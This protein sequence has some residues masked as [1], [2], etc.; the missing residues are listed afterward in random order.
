[1]GR[2]RDK[3]LFNLKV[4]ESSPIFNSFEKR[5][6][7]D[8]LK[9]QL[10]Y[11]GGFA[12]QGADF[13][14]RGEPGNL[15]KVV[16]LYNDKELFQISALNFSMNPKQIIARDADVSMYHENG[17]SLFTSK[18]LFYWDEDKKEL[19]VTAEKK[20]ANLLPFKDSFFKLFINA[21]LLSWTLNS[22]FPMFTYEVGTAQE[23][24]YAFIESWD[25]F[26]KRVF[27]KFAGIGNVNP[28]AE[29]AKLSIE[30]ESLVLPA[31]SYTHLTL[32][33]IYSV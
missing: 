31:V 18:A 28:L 25:F 17:D 32:P 14:G 10:N 11:D 8:G 12:L 3:T 29:I 7:I 16:I 30:E 19:R 20:G 22:P 9:D 2:L 15:A 1:M 13:I 24:K 33:T 4:G 26:D 23:Q 27:Q 5:L 21:P 6:K